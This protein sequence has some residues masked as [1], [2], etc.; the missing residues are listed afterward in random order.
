MRL[1]SLLVALICIL[2]CALFAPAA[3]PA[4]AQTPQPAD[5]LP[6]FVP[7]ILIVGY[8]KGSP[9]RLM[10]LPREAGMAARGQELQALNAL[11]IV[12]ISVPVGQEEQIRQEL[13]QNPDVRYVEMDYLVYA[14][15]IPNDPRWPEQYGPQAV[16]APEAWDITTGSDDI[17]LAVIDS[18][19]DSRHPEF[20]SRLVRG[21]DFIDDDGTPQDDCGHGTHVAGIAAATGN[22]GRGI[23]GIDWHAKVMPIRV[24]HDTGASCSGPTSGLASGIIYAVEHGAKV[25]NLSV[26]LAPGAFSQTLEDAVTYAYQQGVAVFAA[27]GNYGSTSLLHPASAQH[28]MAVGAANRSLS[29]KASFSNA[30]NQPGQRMVVAPGVNILSTTPNHSFLY[31]ESGTTRN[32]GILSGTSMAAPHASGAATLL[33]S[34]PM[35]DTPDKIYQAIT[36]TALDIGPEDGWD[37]NT[38]Y[39][40][41]QIELAMGFEDFTPPSVDEPDVVY[42]YV[43]SVD[44]L[45]L[46]YEWDDAS[47]GRPVPLVSAD[48]RAEIELLSPVMYAGQSFSSITVSA[49]GYVSFGADSMPYSDKTNYPIPWPASPNLLVAPY[50]S[51]LSQSVGGTVYYLDLP[52]RLIIQWDEVSI[53][54]MVPQNSLLTFQVIFYRTSGHIL[55]QYQTLRG[56]HSDGDRGTVGLEYGSSAGTQVSYNQAGKLRPEMAILFIPA[57]P[58]S[59]R[60]VLDCLFVTREE[61]AGCGQLPPFG[62][63]VPDSEPPL[64]EGTELSIRLLRSVPRNWPDNFLPIEAYAD[65]DVEPD[66][67]LAVVCYNYTGADVLR[68]GGRPQNLFLANYRPSGRRWDRLPT[69]ADTLSSQLRA[70]VDHFSIFG[71]FA[72]Q[73]SSLPETGAHQTRIPSLVVFSALGLLAAAAGFAQMRRA[74]R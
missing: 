69:L 48:A 27:A 20:S 71:V 50:W 70:E 23:A 9:P 30:S 14:Q 41:L 60:N 74:R 67:P 24:I 58:G 10:D 11:N 15:L 38:G 19:I 40:L 26:G 53:Q 73:P 49:N 32:Y 35:F 45:Q 22:N 61:F 57:E 34:L 18:G 16:N 63:D 44:C 42:D 33:A 25:I 4:A 56:P 65:I 55:F 1:K 31:E 36:A 13:L 3:R 37:R 68:A 8:E 62:V 5:D 51:D 39:G 72:L 17:V 64:A 2:V 6:P 29:D 46:P 52:D 21:Y 47:V 59:T 12:K 28:A 66:P 7:G 43:S 54:G